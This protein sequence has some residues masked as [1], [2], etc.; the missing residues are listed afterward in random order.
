VIKSE[1]KRPAST[2][3]LD[4]VRDQL[5]QFLS[6]Q[7]LGERVDALVVELGE[8]ADIQQPGAPETAAEPAE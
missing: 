2:T 3:P 4:D 7:K 8:K 5:R 6:S 1:E